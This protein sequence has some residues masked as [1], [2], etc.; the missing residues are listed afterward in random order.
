MFYRDDKRMVLSMNMY[1]ELLISAM[2]ICS[3]AATLVTFIIKVKMDDVDSKK[4]DTKVKE[5]LARIEIK[6]EDSDD[7]LKLML[8]NVKELRE[9]YIISKEQ[10]RKS[11]S[12]A[13]FICFFGIIIYLLGIIAYIFFNKDISVISII[14][15]T[16]VEVIAGLF[17]WLYKESTKQL[18]VYHQRL[19]ATE[20]YLTVIQIIKGMPEDNKVEAFQRLIEAILNDNREII[21][22]EK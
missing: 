10:A 2:P 17:F 15:G 1:T 4:E 8:K 22:H 20:K 11:F 16:V 21:S 3:I 14:G 9:Y 12:A 13:L 18:S 5:A 7:V 19:G 6:S